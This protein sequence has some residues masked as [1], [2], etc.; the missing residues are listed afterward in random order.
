VGEV[1]DLE[2]DGETGQGAANRR[3]G[4]P[5]PQAPECEGLTQRCDICEQPVS[6][7]QVPALLPVTSPAVAEIEAEIPYP[8]SRVVTGIEEAL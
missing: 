3:Q 7:R 8:L 4:R 6:S 5:G 2:N 1:I